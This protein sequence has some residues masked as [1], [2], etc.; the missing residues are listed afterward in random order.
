VPTVSAA[1]T[2]WARISCEETAS[3]GCC[4]CIDSAT[5]V[6][7]FVIILS[8]SS[9]ALSEHIQ[10]PTEAV[11]PSSTRRRARPVGTEAGLGLRAVQGN[12]YR[13]CTGRQR[14]RRLT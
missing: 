5:D 11:S 14:R 6:F 2:E 3:V 1:R 9:S 13:D 8:S 10:Q 7:V 4:I 12:P